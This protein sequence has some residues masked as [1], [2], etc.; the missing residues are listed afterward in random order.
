MV[1][2][3]V[4]WEPAGVV[5]FDDA[6]NYFECSGDPIR[7]QWSEQCNPACTRCDEA[8]MAHAIIDV[9]G[10]DLVI[11]RSLIEEVTF[12]AEDTR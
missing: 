6:R 12:M 9:D 3:H 7:H 8:L 4:C 5:G 11:C 10:E 2:C 1:D